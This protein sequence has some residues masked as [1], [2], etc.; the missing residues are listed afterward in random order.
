[1][2]S[3]SSS[4]L[5]VCVYKR[6]SLLIYCK[7]NKKDYLFDAYF[8]TLDDPPTNLKW[9]GLCFVSGDPSGRARS[10][11]LVHGSRLQSCYTPGAR[12][13]SNIWAED[14]VL[15]KLRTTKTSH[16]CV[17]SSLHTATTAS[18]ERWLSLKRGVVV[19]SSGRLS[20]A[21]MTASLTLTRSFSPLSL[22]RGNHPELVPTWH[23]IRTP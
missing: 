21:T 13:P 11:V 3:I 19:T 23:Q 4:Y 8:G 2:N 17:A 1:M 7:L 9:T 10:P 6:V 12:P 5:F 20:I 18:L 22:P 14:S 15:S 16:L